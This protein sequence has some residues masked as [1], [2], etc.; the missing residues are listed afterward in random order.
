[1]TPQSPRRPASEFAKKLNILAVTSEVPW[2]LDSGGHL[3]TYHL[4]RALA[5]HHQVRLVAPVFATANED[6]RAAL[7]RAGIASRFVSV[8]PRTRAAEYKKAIVA[9]SRREPYV[10]FARH[11]YSAVRQM[12]IEESRRSTPDLL[13]LDHLDSLV[14]ACEPLDAPRVLDMHNIYSRLT[15][16]GAVEAQGCIRRWYLLR[17]ARL[18]AR[19]EQHAACMARTIFAVS[20]IE[21]VYF[22]SIGAQRVVVVPNGVD[23]AAYQ[24]LPTGS[25][26]GPP[27]ILYIGSLAWAPNLSAARHLATKVL[28]FVRGHLPQARLTIVGHDPPADLLALARADDHITIAENVGDVRPHLR[29]AHVLAVPLQ[30]G[31][32][33]RLKILEAFAAGLPVVSTSVGCEGIHATPG[34]DLV[35]A[36]LPQ[37]AA[38]IVEVLRDPS[39]AQ[40]RARHARQLVRDLYDWGTI[41]THVLNAVACAAAPDR[42]GAVSVSDRPP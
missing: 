8:S 12:L 29:H 9:A 10:M 40:Q 13:Y 15:A 41:G 14:Y 20:D 6:N 38:T 24:S 3:R 28:P 19:M 22:H 37:F 31:S 30:S 17:E 23:W 35:V 4:L 21:A 27:T 42:T 1:V 18:L 26:T 2:P 34:E 25:R 39:R 32:G 33:T 16:R 36:D 5:T 11:R 7:E